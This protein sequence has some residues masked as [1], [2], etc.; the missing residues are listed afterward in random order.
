MSNPALMSSEVLVSIDP[1]FYSTVDMSSEATS[2]SQRVRTSFVW[3]TF[4]VIGALFAL[5]ITH[6]Y[7]P[8]NL[9]VGIR[10]PF[11][12]VRGQYLQVGAFGYRVQHL[13]VST[14]SRPDV[15]RVSPTSHTTLAAPEES[16]T[17]ASA[18]LD[19]AFSKAS[20]LLTWVLGPDAKDMTVDK[21]ERALRMMGDVV[22]QRKK[23]A[24]VAA[25]PIQALAL[26]EKAEQEQLLVSNVLAAMLLKQDAEQAL[27][28]SGRVAAES[29]GAQLKSADSSDETNTAP[30]DWSHK[31]VENPKAAFS[32]ASAVVDRALDEA[33]V[34]LTWLLGQDAKDMT[35]EKAER[36]LRMVGDVVQQR[37]EAAKVAADPIQALAS[38]EKAEQEQLLVSNVLAAMLLKQDAEQ[39]LRAVE[40]SS[41]DPKREPLKSA[42]ASDGKQI[43][44]DLQQAFDSARATLDRALDRAEGIVAWL[45]GADAKDMTVQKA[46]RALRMMGDVVQQ[47]KEAAEVAADPIQALALVEKAEQEQLL[48]SNVLAAMLLKQDAEQALRGSGRAAGPSPSLPAGSETASKESF[49]TNPEDPQEAFDAASAALDRAFDKAEMVFA[50]LLGADARDMNLEKAQK[51]LKLVDALV[52]KRR[53]AARVASDPVQAL[54]LLQKAEKKQLLVKNVVSAMLL[55]QDAEQALARSELAAEPLVDESKPAPPTPAA[56]FN[57]D[58]SSESKP[59]SPNTG[60]S[61]ASNAAPTKAT[62]PSAAMRQ[63]TAWDRRVLG[64]VF[65]CLGLLLTGSS[66]YFY[67]SL[68]LV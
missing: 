27:R 30:K 53:K 13:P 15:K 3:L 18:A 60:P 20:P 19:E 41:A 23:A 17:A 52:H 55:K 44:P 50:W 16:F 29:K 14:I 32:A 62:E 28:G 51:A 12:G 24:E 6:A 1:R 8:Q 61:A 67:P 34:T 66:F 45:L 9:H 57:G 11:Q 48:V 2:T 39:A 54:A 10:S 33:E 4:G 64:T 7:H 22:Q 63:Y 58:E 49:R 46:E 26:V 56:L 25:D 42:E 43:A 65:M 59:M 21:A 31:N 36:A 5:G 37:K 35:I 68:L 38:V 40:P 47:R